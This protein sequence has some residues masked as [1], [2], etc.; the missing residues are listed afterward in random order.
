MGGSKKHLPAVPLV[1]SVHASKCTVPSMCHH[2]P[3]SCHQKYSPSKTSAL[4]PHPMLPHPPSLPSPT[5]QQPSP[6][7]WATHDC[8][9][10]HCTPIDF[11]AYD[12]APKDGAA[13]GGTTCDG[14]NHHGAAYHAT[15]YDG[16]AYDS[17]N[18]SGTAFDCASKDLPMQL[19]FPSHPSP[20]Q[21]SNVKELSQ[22]DVPLLK[23]QKNFRCVFV[24]SFHFL[25]FH[26]FKKRLTNL[27]LLFV[28]GWYVFWLPF[29]FWPFT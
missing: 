25:H 8:A 21:Q 22:R 16:T 1:P 23:G 18:A 29:Y 9:P 2:L 12:G 28:M 20:S 26:N 14:N 11:A 24:C 15:M 19:L 7:Y 27:F 3:P 10:I 17:A 6:W 5:P 4:W 13:C